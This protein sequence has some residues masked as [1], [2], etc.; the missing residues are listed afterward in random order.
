M[1]YIYTGNPFETIDKRGV[2][3]IMELALHKIR[4]STG[5]G[6]K[7][8]NRAY[9]TAGGRYERGELHMGVCGKHAGDPASIHYFN[10]LKM[11]FVSV[12]PKKLSVALL[13]A[14]KANVKESAGTSN[15]HTHVHIAL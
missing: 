8:S 4:S 11:N 7:S 1:S 12:P 2:G 6:E 15:T 14:A 3:S 5:T 10:H 13:S 9:H